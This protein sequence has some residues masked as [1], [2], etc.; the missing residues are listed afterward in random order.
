MATTE[1]YSDVRRTMTME[2]YVWEMKCN[3]HDRGG[4]RS[5]STDDCQGSYLWVSIVQLR[6]LKIKAF[7]EIDLEIY[8]FVLDQQTVFKLMI[9]SWKEASQLFVEGLSVV[10][11]LYGAQVPS[12]CYDI[13]HI[14]FPSS[15]PFLIRNHLR[16][17]TK[18]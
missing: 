15:L 16:Q 9:G 4:C 2:E 12:I 1:A 11:E 18:L 5:T 17:H 7:P 6:A 10:D 3:K 13:H 8:Q 14:R